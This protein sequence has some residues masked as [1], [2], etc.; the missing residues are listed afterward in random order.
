MAMLSPGMI[1]GECGEKIDGGPYVSV[2]W[3]RDGNGD[4]MEPVYMDYHKRCAE[5]SFGHVCPE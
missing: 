5:M 2:K 4:P 3:D 1:C